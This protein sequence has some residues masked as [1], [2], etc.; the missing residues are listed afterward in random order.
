MDVPGDVLVKRDCMM[1]PIGER[2]TERLADSLKASF[3]S[4]APVLSKGTRIGALHVVAFLQPCGAGSFLLRP[5]NGASL[6][7]RHLTP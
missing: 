7:R 2:S 1:Q 5:W 3:H 6:T 4:K